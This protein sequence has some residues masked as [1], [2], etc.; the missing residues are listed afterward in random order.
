[1]FYWENPWGVEPREVGDEG[2]EAKECR[3]MAWLTVSPPDSERWTVGV[4]PSP[5]FRLLDDATGTEDE[6]TA[7]GGG[8]SEYDKAQFS[9]AVMR[10]SDAA[11][12]PY[13]EG[14]NR[15]I[16]WCC[17]GQ[18]RTEWEEE[19]NLKEFD[20]SWEGKAEANL[21][22]QYLF[23][24]HNCW[25]LGPDE[26]KGNELTVRE[27]GDGLKTFVM[28]TDNCEVWTVGVVPAEA[29][30]YLDNSTRR[31]HSFGESKNDEQRWGQY[32]F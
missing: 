10:P 23:F 5:S 7:L 29:F 20:S 26:F 27:A 22:A 16:V 15:F 11:K 4:V 30:D 21:R 8:E 12:K 28:G 32:A 14:S 17:T 9:D 25:G 24:W 19:A 3:G 13:S 2:F 6:A 31:R 18:D 1:M